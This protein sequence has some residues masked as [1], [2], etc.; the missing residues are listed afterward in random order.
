VVALWRRDSFDMLHRRVVTTA[1]TTIKQLVEARDKVVELSTKKEAVNAAFIEWQTKAEAEIDA[2]EKEL[3]AAL[4]EYY[5][6]ETEF[7][8]GR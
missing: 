6:V 5:K 7:R 1:M 4:N 8:F 2:V 3:G